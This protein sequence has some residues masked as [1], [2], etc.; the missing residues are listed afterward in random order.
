MR[1]DMRTKR[2]VAAFMAFAVAA[3]LV[4]YCGSPSWAEDDESVAL[5]SGIDIYVYAYPLVLMDVTS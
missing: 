4:C 2:V 5:D 3:Q 1:T